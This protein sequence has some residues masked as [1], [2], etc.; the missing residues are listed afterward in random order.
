MSMYEKEDIMRL[1]E[2]EDVEFIRLQFTDIF[3]TMK[4]IAI[5]SSQLERALNNRFMFDGT[6]IEGYVRKGEADMYLH[7]DKDTMEIFPW[8][9]QQGKVARM[10]C[11]VHLPDKSPFQG[12]S[13]QVLKK[14]ME[15]AKELGYLFE[16]GPECEF[17]LFNT[18]DNGMPTTTVNEQAGYFDIGPIDNG[19]NVRRDIVLTLEDMGFVVEASHHESAPGQHEVDFKYADAL[20]TADRLM[21]FKMVAKTMAKRHGYWATFMPKPVEGVGGS[22]MHLNM[23]MSKDGKNI[24]HD[25][26]NEYGLSQ[27][28]LYFIGGLMKHIK[29]LT[30]ITNP[31]VN[32][33]KRLVPNYYA[34]V[35]ATWGKSCFNPL[36][37]VPESAG[38]TTRVEL[39]SP[40]PSTNPY[41]AFA[42]CLAAGLDGI[43]NKIEPPKMT[44]MDGADMTK[45]ERESLGIE[46][47][48]M[49]LKEAIEALKKDDLLKETLGEHI[50][51][52]FVEVKEKE[53]AEY[54]SA[55]STWEVQRYLYKI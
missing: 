51:N 33:Y 47:L 16:V 52:R 38:E 55:V 3:G 44:L 1:V 41:L 9:P 23:S 19:E 34:P 39:R 37:R 36:I 26:N 18:D 45:E 24:F 30:A 11:D 32:S 14:V 13:R 28:A 46:S 40:D 4:N 35:Y 54:A 2:E 48:P 31:L 42:V 27:E 49:N 8:R 5:T 21:T 7:P 53:W 10:I 25:E 15:E 22:G 43:K 12:D 17:F 6:S 20:T 29:A 50:F